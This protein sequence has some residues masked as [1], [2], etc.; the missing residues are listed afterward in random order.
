MT[1]RK[2]AHIMQ[3]YEFIMDL[4]FLQ[5]GFAGGKRPQSYMSP[6][7]LFND[8]HPCDHRIII[9]GSGGDKIVA[10]DCF[11]CM[12]L[13]HVGTSIIITSRVLR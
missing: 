6:T 3:S 4:Y 12:S 9:G 5:N 11:Y 7:I 2:L 13:L 1:Y 10:G 8:E